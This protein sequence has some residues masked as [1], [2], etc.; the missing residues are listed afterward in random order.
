MKWLFRVL[1]VV[2]F[3]Y[4]ISVNGWEKFLEVCVGVFGV[5]LIGD[6]YDRLLRIEHNQ[7]ALFKKFERPAI[8]QWEID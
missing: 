3:I 6:I 5:W 8:N 7:V 4:Y 1:M 2:G